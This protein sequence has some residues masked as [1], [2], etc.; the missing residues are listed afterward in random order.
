MVALVKGGGDDD[1][2]S[3]DKSGDVNSGLLVMDSDLNSELVKM[4]HESKMYPLHYL[5]IT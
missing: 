3:R 5:L 1:Q 4:I 2:V